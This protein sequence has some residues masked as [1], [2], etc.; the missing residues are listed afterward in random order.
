MG[1]RVLSSSGLAGFVN[2]LGEGFRVLV[3]EDGGQAVGN[4]SFLLGTLMATR[5]RLLLKAANWDHGPSDLKHG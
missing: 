2:R 1:L 3:F 4:S 5:R